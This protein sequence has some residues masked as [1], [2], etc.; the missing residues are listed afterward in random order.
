[1]SDSQKQT[2]N[3]YL[4]FKLGEELFASH[5]ENVIKIL[6]MQHITEVPRTPD[7]MK[8]VIN[9]R[10]NVLPVID[11]RIKFGIPQTEYNQKTCILVLSI[12]IDDEQVDVGAIVDAVHD[13]FEYDP[14]KILP[15]PSLGSKFKSGFIDGVMKVDEKFIMIL[16][17]NSVFSTEEIIDIQEQTEKTVEKLK[18]DKSKKKAI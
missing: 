12:R 16:N 5:V 17:M 13:V 9:L 8:G 6:E 1:M 18:K 4:T 7:Y 14:D 11:A 2:L 10:G 3:S 15:P